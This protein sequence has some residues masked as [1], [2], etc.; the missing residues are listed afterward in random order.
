MEE[1]ICQLIGCLAEMLIDIPE[2]F[3]YRWFRWTF[4]ITMVAL[5]G[6]AIYFYGK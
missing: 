1:L 6:L 3:R 2:V 5:T 4:G